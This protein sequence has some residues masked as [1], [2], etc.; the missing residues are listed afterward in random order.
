MSANDFGGFGNAHRS[1]GAYHFV[2]RFSVEE[3]HGDVG[4]RDLAS[5]GDVDNA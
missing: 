5:F 4:E 2:E 3:F 1:F